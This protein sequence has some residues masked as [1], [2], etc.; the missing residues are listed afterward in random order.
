MGEIGENSLA[1]N[2]GGSQWIAYE[3]LLK[4]VTA[5]VNNRE[6][7]SFQNLEVALRT[8]RRDFL[9]L[10]KNPIKKP[11]SRESVKKAATEGIRVIGYYGTK[12][13]TKSQVDEALIISDL[14][15][16]NEVAALELLLLAEGQQSR[17]G[18]KTRGLAAVVLYYS[19]RQS[20]ITALRILIQARSGRSWTLGASNEITDLITRFTDDLWN[21]GL[22]DQIFWHLES[23]KLDHEQE[24][25]E[26]KRALGDAKHRKQVFDLL[27][28][29]QTTLAECLYC[30]SCQCGLEK[31]YT[32]RL[33]NIL[34]NITPSR[35]DG[36]LDSMQIALLMACFYSIDL[37]SLT[38]VDES[39][40]LFQRF[41]LIAE[42]E[43][44]PSLH[45]EILNPKPWKCPS[46]KA[47]IQFAWGVSL[48]TLSQAPSM[49]GSRR[50][51]CVEDDEAVVEL[52]LES[53]ALN[54]IS[55]LV[56]GNPSFFKEEFFIRRIHGIVTDF[57]VNMPLTIKEL[58]NRGDEVAKIV[59]HS[60]PTLNQ[61][62][63]PPMYFSMFMDLVVNKHYNFF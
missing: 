34:T 43:F 17:L 31:S 22:A 27:D 37:T 48:R 13:L 53:N 29:I 39:D 38:T 58:R 12:V 5:A 56:I 55:T 6:P 9:T 62:S 50:Q 26:D 61:S 40:E 32:L 8:Y 28:D 10:L 57:I 3:E 47:I 45:K 1:V 30:W 59:A 46:L 54:S 33:F 24:K 7:T 49:Q 21:E 15:D 18:V 60:D 20:L 16:L 2:L 36:N 44:V 11:E 4:V 14:F 25:L 63:V 52:A 35:G 23:F 51:Q 42:E 19:G 41:P